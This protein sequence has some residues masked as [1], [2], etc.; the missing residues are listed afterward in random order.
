MVTRQHEARHDEFNP[1]LRVASLI[2]H[3]GHI[4]ELDDGLIQRIVTPERILEVSIPVR[5]DS[6]KVDVFTGW[7]IQHDSSRGPGKGGIRFHQSV[8]VDEIAALSADMSIK[9][10]VVNIPYGGAKGGVNVDPD[11]LSRDELERLT[12]RYAFAIAPMIGPD[13][14]IP[15]PDINTDP[16][17]MSWIMDTVSMLRGHSMPGVVTGKPLAIGG[18]YGHAGAT[19]LGVTIC[20]LGLL[21]QLGLSPEGQ[22][23]V[24]QG[25]GKVGGPLI[26]LLADR[27]MKVVGLADIHGAIHVPEGLD[28]HRMA[29]HF[30]EA[31]TIIGYP[32]AEE[33]APDAFFTIPSDIAIPAALGGVVD[34]KVASTMTASM[35]VEAANGPTTGEGAA[36]LAE[37]GV[38]VVPDVLANAGGVVASYFEWAQD[39]QGFM[40]EHELFTKRLEKFMQ[41]AFDSV[42]IRHQQLGLEL[43]DTALVVG[44][45]RIAEATKLRGL[46]P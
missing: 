8:N 14:D 34:E 11:T 46:F 40:W 16:Q 19:S 12:R 24:I 36:I 1:W 20:T 44:V 45:E 22:R 3:A 9:C 21:K 6:G 30:D 26:K 35:M 31:H 37:R 25:Y 10:A 42:W 13:R 2:E 39:M 41:E 15:A 4:L 18:S 38:P 27:G 43:R 33:V 29:D 32:G 17:V 28:A 5:R 7:R 23:V